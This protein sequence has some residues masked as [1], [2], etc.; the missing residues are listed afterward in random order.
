MRVGGG[1]RRL[2]A[3]L[4]GKPSFMWQ[5]VPYSCDVRMSHSW[6]ASLAYAR[7]EGRFKSRPPQ[8][9]LG[10]LSTIED[11]DRGC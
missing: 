7:S 6:T 10:A 9:N 4:G 1:P 3:G 5:A 2:S 11:R 8:R